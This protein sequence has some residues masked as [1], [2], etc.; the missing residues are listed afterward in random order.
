MVHFVL[1]SL[2]SVPLSNKTTAST[3]SKQDLVFELQVRA[4]GLLAA[5]VA[6]A[7]SHA[8]ALWELSRQRQ[9][10]TELSV[11]LDQALTNAPGAY[12]HIDRRIQAYECNLM[13][14]EDLESQRLEIKELKRMYRAAAALGDSRYSD[15][16]G[17]VALGST[18]SSSH[19]ESHDSRLLPRS[20]GIRGRSR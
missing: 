11:A 2:S 13:T 18:S 7:Q 20:T 3:S 6:M 12:G 19:S 1:Q 14:L 8:E 10:N 17:D 9:A 16:D 15:S 5:R 4:A